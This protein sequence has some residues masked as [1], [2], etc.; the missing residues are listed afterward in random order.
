[1]VFAVGQTGDPEPRLD[2][3][4]DGLYPGYTQPRVPRIFRGSHYRPKS[5]ERRGTAGYQDSGADGEPEIEH[6]VG[7]VWGQSSFTATERLRNPL[8]RPGS[9]LDSR[10][11]TTRPQGLT[12]SLLPPPPPSMLAA[13]PS[14]EEGRRAR[15][16]VC[17]RQMG[18]LSNRLLGWGDL[19]RKQGTGLWWEGG[20]HGREGGRGLR[21]QRVRCTDPQRIS[22]QQRM[23]GISRAAHP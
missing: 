21:K 8:Q 17:W 18:R 19:L 1:M 2:R 22:E 7:A 13:K 3:E 14:S 20:N 11:D 4:G 5:P 15:W 12:P 10:P 6:E 23:L 9:C 16:S